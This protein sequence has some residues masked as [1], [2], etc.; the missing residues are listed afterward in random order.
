MTATQP[1]RRR[2][3]SAGRVTA[4]VVINCLLLVGVLVEILP[5]VYMALGAF[6]PNAE[7]FG[8]PLSLW[9]RDWTLDN[10]RALF[11]DFPLVRWTVN[12]AVVAVVGTVLAVVLAS[13]A[14]FAFAKQEFRFKRTLLTVMLV[15]LLLPSQ[16]LLV[17]Q[18][19]IMRTLDWFNTYQGLIV[20]RAVTA[21]G[22]ILM[23]QFTL[24][25]PDELLDAARVDGATEFRLWWRIVVPLVKPGIAVLGMLTFL[26]L[27]NDYFWPLI[28]TTE[29]DMFVLNLGISS[30]IG[31]YD[32]RYGMVLAGALL[33]SLPVILVFTFFQRQFVAGLMRGALK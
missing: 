24:S 3:V 19:Q 22:I 14:G 4:I 13:L 20:P 27:W 1:T 2:R 6:K 26:Q 23:R 9:P 7:I 5:Y 10:L 16:V 12:T 28:I 8:V 15:T 17:P 29:P 21:F 31:P 33:A 32:F 30:L 18:F 25:V 11:D